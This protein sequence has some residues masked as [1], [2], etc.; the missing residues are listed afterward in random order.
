MKGQ[1]RL[2]LS[3]FA[4]I[5]SMLWSSGCATS[6]PPPFVPQPETPPLSPQAQPPA[7]LETYLDSVSELL[8]KWR[9]ELAR[10]LSP[11]GNAPPNTK[12]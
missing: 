11:T 2:S 4:L 7:D 3:G 9:D 1:N 6:S 8:K 10:S 5:A 12:P